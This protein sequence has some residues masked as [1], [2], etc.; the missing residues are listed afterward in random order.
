MKFQVYDDIISPTYQD[1]L[2]SLIS[3]PDLPWNWQDSMDNLP[4]SSDTKSGGYPQFIRDIF[5][6]GQVFDNVLYHAT[7]GL[8]STVVDDLIP[9]YHLVRTRWILQTP[10]AEDIKHYPP[11]TDATNTSGVSAI[12]YPSDSTGDTYLFNECDINDKVEID[13]FNHKWEP[14]D[15]VSPKKG[16]LIVFPSNN[17][18]AGSPTTSERRMLININFMTISNL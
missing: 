5:N 13:R 15:C 9:G 16:R 18:H 7:L 17:Y 14:V 11:H 12:Y 1:V 2:E 3:S 8:V 4:S 6:N 10:R